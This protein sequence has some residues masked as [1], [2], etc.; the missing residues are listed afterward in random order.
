LPPLVAQNA[1]DRKGRQARIGDPAAFKVEQPVEWPQPEQT[2]SPV[3]A[4]SVRSPAAAM[5]QSSSQNLCLAERPL[6][7]KPADCNGHILLKNSLIG[8]KEGRAK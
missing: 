4:E 8:E 2:D 7:R 3:V 1:T 5:E 6:C